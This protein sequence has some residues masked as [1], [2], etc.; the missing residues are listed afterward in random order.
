MKIQDIPPLRELP[1][2][3][4]M[5]RVHAAVE[6]STGKRWEPD[7][8]CQWWCPK[9]SCSQMTLQKWLDLVRWKEERHQ[10][11]AEHLDWGYGAWCAWRNR[12]FDFAGCEVRSFMYLL[13]PASNV[14]SL[15]GPSSTLTYASTCSSRFNSNKT[16][17]EKHSLVPTGKWLM[18]S[19]TVFLV[20]SNLI[21]HVQLTCVSATEPNRD[22]STVSAQ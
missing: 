3:S 6:A 13:P 7:P 5:L 9:G 4:G 14:L 12:E 21:I 1:A 20:H 22:W 11:Q 18:A 10:R 15:P 2:W 8:A 17:S 19:L 16:S